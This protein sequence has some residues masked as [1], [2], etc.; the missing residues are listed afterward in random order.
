MNQRLK[1]HKMKMWGEER[2]WRIVQPR[3]SSFLVKFK[4]FS[5]YDR[6]SLVK[7][8]TSKI[9]EKKVVDDGLHIV[10]IWSEMFVIG[11]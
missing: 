6:V 1:V 2:L 10:R 7:P 8:K 9:C 5:F 4:A 3:A 11:C